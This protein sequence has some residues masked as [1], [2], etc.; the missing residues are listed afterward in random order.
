MIIVTKGC[1]K[2]TAPI[3]FNHMHLS[4]QMFVNCKLYGYNCPVW[5]NNLQIMIHTKGLRGK[6]QLS[7]CQ[8]VIICILTISAFFFT[9]NYNLLALC[10]VLIFHVL[11]NKRKD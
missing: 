10:T 1:R 2:I 6:V 4:V 11:E 3:F 8:S 5:T 7:F 9:Q